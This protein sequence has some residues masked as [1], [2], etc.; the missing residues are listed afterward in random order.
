MTAEELK[1]SSVARKEATY[2]V[3]TPKRRILKSTEPTTI[4]KKENG[5]KN[6]PAR[7]LEN[8]RRHKEKDVREQRHYYDICKY[9]FTEKTAF[10][11]TMKV[12]G[13]LRSRLTSPISP[14]LRA[15]STYLRLGT[16]NS[17]ATK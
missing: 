14:Y 17:G 15:I 12:T 4:R 9:A 3:R 10:R 8:S 16:L 6:N 13:P 11:D 5:R 7:K 1:E 2:A